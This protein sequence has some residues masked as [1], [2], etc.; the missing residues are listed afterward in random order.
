MEVTLVNINKTWALNCTTILLHQTVK[1]IY[2]CRSTHW[3]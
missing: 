1:Y 2:I 3:C